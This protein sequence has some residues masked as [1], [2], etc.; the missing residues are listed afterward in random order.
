ME[1]DCRHRVVLIRGMGGRSRILE[2]DLNILI[3]WLKAHLPRY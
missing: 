2:D 3:E 1:K